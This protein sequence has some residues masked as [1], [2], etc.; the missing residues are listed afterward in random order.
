M[1]PVE[2]RVTGHYLDRAA[3]E[4]LCYQKT[5]IQA[6]LFLVGEIPFH[7]AFEEAYRKATRP[8]Q[9]Q[10]NPRT[11]G[12]KLALKTLKTQLGELKAIIEFQPD[13]MTKPHSETPVGMLTENQIREHLS[14]R[15]LVEEKS[16]EKKETLL[17]FKRLKTTGILP[18]KTGSL[19]SPPTEEQ[20]IMLLMF[21]NKQLRLTRKL[22]Q[23]KPFAFGPKKDFLSF[24]QNL[25]WI[26]SSLPPERAALR[27]K[28]PGIQM[29]GEL[30]DFYEGVFAARMPDPL[31]ERVFYLSRH[32]GRYLSQIGLLPQNTVKPDLMI[33]QEGLS[34]ENPNL[35][36]FLR[37]SHK[38]G[39]QICLLSCQERLALNG[40][41][42][43]LVVTCSSGPRGK[44]FC[45]D[46][47]FCLLTSEEYR[48]FCN[49]V[50]YAV[51]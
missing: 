25:G 51:K 8:G 1:M 24:M 23:E 5:I 27:Q 28:Q 41:P 12:P 50:I 43:V 4:G 9:P 33:S 35:Q 46:Y 10:F 44:K 17:W 38:E 42:A 45:R 18:E 34:Q 32:A 6:A 29:T 31:S 2:A 7:E 16:A 13:L 11:D 15:R 30:L 21:L 49:C 14:S 19:D 26:L 48:S 39:A 47:C 22:S 36:D 3:G 37:S 40:D 20:A